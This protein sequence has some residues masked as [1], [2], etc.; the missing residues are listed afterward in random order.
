[1]HQESRVWTLEHL[2]TI[3]LKNIALKINELI[4]KPINDDASF[5]QVCNITYRVKES[6]IRL[7]MND[8][9][10]VCCPVKKVT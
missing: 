6:S 9:A 2:E 8:P 10:F 7:W 5:I 4:E 3:N 1:M